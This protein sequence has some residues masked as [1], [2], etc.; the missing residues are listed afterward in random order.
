MSEITQHKRVADVLIIHNANHGASGPLLQNDVL[1]NDVL[2]NGAGQ[3]GATPSANM[4][5]LLV[6][7]VWKIKDDSGWQMPSTRERA[8]LKDSRHSA[9]G[10]IENGETAAQGASNLM[11]CLHA[12]REA[13]EE[14]GKGAVRVGRQLVEVIE[15]DGTIAPTIAPTIVHVFEGHLNFEVPV[16][17]DGAEIGEYAWFAADIAADRMNPLSANLFRAAMEKLQVAA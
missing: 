11:A 10:H 13:D 2:Q 8:Q 7:P 5:V 4:G 9:A 3:V 1:Q 6:R 17:V 14:L 15:D 16:T 12:Q